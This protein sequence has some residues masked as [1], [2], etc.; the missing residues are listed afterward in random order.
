[1]SVLTIDEQPSLTNPV[2]VLTFAG[3]NDAGGAATHAM[4]FLIQHLQARKFASLDPEE[5]YDFTTVRPRVKLR[6][7]FY[8]EITWPANEFFYSRAANSEQNL[9]LGLGIE[10]QLKWKTFTGAI[11]DLAK[12]CGVTMVVTLGALL[13]DVV[14]SRPTRVIGVSNDPSLAAKLP[15]LTRSRY[16][17]PTGVVSVT[18]DTCRRAGIPSASFWANVPHYV[19]ISPN[20]K[21]AHALI[22]RLASF[23]DFPIDTTE[24]ESAAKEFNARLVEAIAQN[25]NV[26]AYVKQLEE[27]DPEDTA[28][29]MQ[30]QGNGGNGH[31]NGKDFEEEL[32][33]LLRKNRGEK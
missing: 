11:L 9:I 19:S 15:Q 16:E 27:R 8:R 30:T 14:Y 10:P 13:A 32:Q 5:F 6:D 31:A 7:G 28:E 21:A 20:P 1:M 24:L 23:L 26:A 2:L 12:Q 3:W 17:G 4:Q 18:N 29:A 25:P 22:V 33:R